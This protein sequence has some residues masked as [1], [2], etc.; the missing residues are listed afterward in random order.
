MG[1]QI[2]RR[3]V[4]TVAVILQYYCKDCKDS[5]VLHPKSRYTE[6]EKAK[7]LRAYNERMSM[8]GIKRVLGVS[9]I[10]FAR[11]IKKKAQTQNSSL[12]QTLT[13]FNEDYILELEVIAIFGMFIQK[14]FP[15]I[16]IDVWIRGVVRPIT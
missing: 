11:W 9:P 5:K 16:G 15:K 6:T 13:H 3:I 4:T 12:L 14:Y 8:R 1:V 10:T 7:I 2:L